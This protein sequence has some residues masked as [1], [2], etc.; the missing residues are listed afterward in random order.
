[1]IKKISGII[2]KEKRE[3]FKKFLKNNYIFDND[4]IE[5]NNCRQLEHLIFF[6]K[7]EEEVLSAYNNPY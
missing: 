6:N 5:N 1:M 3:G 2:R 4:I 7:I